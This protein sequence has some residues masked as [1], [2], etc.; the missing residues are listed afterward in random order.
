MSTP[1]LLAQND[2]FGGGPPGAFFAVFGVVI[3]VAL[4]IALAIMAVILYILYTCF[5][6]IPPEHRQMDSWQVFLLLIPCFNIIW[7]FF[8]YPRLAESYQSYFRSVGRTDVGDCGQ[9]VGLWYAICSAVSIIPIVNYIAGPAS[10]V[11]LIIFLVKAASLKGQIPPGG[12]P[13]PG[14]YPQAGGFPPQ[15]GKM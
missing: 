12:K 3:V 8:V 2:P 5:E 9:Q 13:T 11:L 4:L 7:N 10:L 15:E 14:G 6:R 1:L